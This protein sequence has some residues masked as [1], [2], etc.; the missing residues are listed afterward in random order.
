VLLS[1]SK[2]LINLLSEYVIYIHVAENLSIHAEDESKGIHTSS[3][4]LIKLKITLQ[5]LSWRSLLKVC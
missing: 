1:F 3:A 5:L 2:E 4:V